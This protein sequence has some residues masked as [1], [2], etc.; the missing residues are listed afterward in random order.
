[1]GAGNDRRQHRFSSAAER[2][3]S[4]AETLG[5]KPRWAESLC[6]ARSRE[7]C[8]AIWLLALSGAKTTAQQPASSPQAG[9]ESARNLH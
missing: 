4:S 6:V 1:M 3:A 9:G 5:L 8:S 7:C 2:A